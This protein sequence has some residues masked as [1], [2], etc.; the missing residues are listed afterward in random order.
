MAGKGIRRSV[1]ESS[2]DEGTQSKL[3]ILQ[4]KHIRLQDELHKTEQSLEQEMAKN[5]RLMNPS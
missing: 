3:L 2:T 5:H 4:E 1:E